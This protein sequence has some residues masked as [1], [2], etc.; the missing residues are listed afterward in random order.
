LLDCYTVQPEDYIT[1]SRT[2]NWSRW[3]ARRHYIVNPRKANY[4]RGLSLTW[5][6]EGRPC[7]LG[8]F[9]GPVFEFASMM[10]SL[11]PR[12]D[13]IVRRSS[14]HPVSH[15]GIP[16]VELTMSYESRRWSNIVRP[17]PSK[18]A[19]VVTKLMDDT[20]LRVSGDHRDCLRWSGTACSLEKCL[21]AWHH[22]NFVR[23]GKA[24][25]GLKDILVRVQSTNKQG[26]KK[27]EV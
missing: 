27:K 1:F 15:R 6:A 2:L 13:P 22:H 5:E 4:R 18:L 21:I 23:F 14:E 12:M 25:E 26:R 8:C 7:N 10:E 19:I 3:A 9:T 11:A 17:P 20:L 24:R 16:G